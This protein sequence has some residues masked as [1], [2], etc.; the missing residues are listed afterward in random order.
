M[1][2]KAVAQLTISRF[3]F[4]GLFISY[5]LNSLCG[6]LALSF[7]LCCLYAI[8]F[9]SIIIPLHSIESTR[10]LHMHRYDDNNNFFLLST[11][12]CGGL[13]RQSLENETDP[14]NSKEN[15]AEISPRQQPALKELAVV[16]PQMTFAIV[17]F[18]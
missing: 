2:K 4:F 18:G 11:T 13:P 9:V 17:K 8:I 14:Y 16:V 5:A 1:H 10:S 15:K 7:F 3:H 12:L 6:R